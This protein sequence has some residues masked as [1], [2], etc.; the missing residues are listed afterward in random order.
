MYTTCNLFAKHT[1]HAKQLLYAICQ[2]EQLSLLQ[3][4]VALTVHKTSAAI[5][6]LSRSSVELHDL[7]AT[8]VN[9]VTFVTENDHI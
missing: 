1:K 2:S 6:Q 9:C 5:H 7:P 8:L 4:M 3:H